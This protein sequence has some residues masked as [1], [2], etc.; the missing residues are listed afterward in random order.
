[1]NIMDEEGQIPEEHFDLLGVRIDKDIHGND[2]IRAVNLSQESSQHS[3]C[4]T[5]SHQVD[6]QLEHLQTIKSEEIEKKTTANMKQEELVQANK[7]VVEVICSKL[8]CDGLI[9]ECAEVCEEHMNLCSMKILSEL[10]N[11][12]LE[13][14]ILARDTSVTKSQLPTKGKLNDAEDNNVRNRICLAFNC[15][16]MPNKIE[17]TLP[18]DLYNQA[19]EDEAE[20]YSFHKITLTEDSTIPPSTLLSDP[21]WMMYVIRLLDLETKGIPTWSDLTRSLAGLGRNVLRPFSLSLV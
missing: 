16:T 13:A 4:V 12:Q 7:K 8:V 17:G 1:M 10:T 14:F 5:H 21:A 2:V 15:R 18:F 19:D 11:P 6:L 3:K 9:D 20:N